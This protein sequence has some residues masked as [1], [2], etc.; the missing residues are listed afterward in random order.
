M[1]GL[2]PSNHVEVTPWDVFNFSWNR[3]HKQTRN[4]YPL[5]HYWVYFFLMNFTGNNNWRSTYWWSICWIYLIKNIWDMHS[6]HCRGSWFC[7][8]DD[9]A[10]ARGVYC[11]DSNCPMSCLGFLP[12]WTVL[13]NHAIA[14]TCFHIPEAFL[15]LYSCRIYEYIIMYIYFYNYHIVV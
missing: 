7:L 4:S 9:F 6:E 12:T 11:L 3:L 2:S 8:A 10:Q 5:L 13:Y 1:N 15:K 14:Q